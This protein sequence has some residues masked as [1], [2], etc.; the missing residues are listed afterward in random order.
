M[1][2][3]QATKLA[4]NALAEVTVTVE[5]NIGGDVIQSGPVSVADAVV[6]FFNPDG[7]WSV[8]DN[9]EEVVCDTEDDVI[10]IIVENLSL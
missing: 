4:R 3:T 10:R 8:C 2:K 9:G 5:E 1:T 7:T 6:L